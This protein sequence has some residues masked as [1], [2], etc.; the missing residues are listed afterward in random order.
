MKTRASLVGLAVVVVAA[1][2]P[3]A[4]VAAPVAAAPPPV[5]SSISNLRQEVLAIE[6][7]VQADGRKVEMEGEAY[8][9]ESILL[10]RDR[11]KLR[12]TDA[13]IKVEQA[14]VATEKS[15][16]T[17]AAIAAYIGSGG[18]T[19][20]V[21]EFLTTDAND[22]QLVGTYSTTIAQNLD[23]ALNAYLASEHRLDAVKAVQTAEMKAAQAAAT[24]AHKAEVAA[25]A[26]T[27]A[28]EQL[29]SSVKGQLAHAIAAYQ[30]ELLKAAEAAAAAA[31]AREIAAQQAAA[32][33]A[34]KRAHE[35]QQGGGGGTGGGGGGTGDG[36][37][38]GTYP[39]GGSNAGTPATAAQG[40]QAVAAAVKLIGVPYVWGGA[41]PSG[42]DCSGLTMI[43]WDQAG[44]YMDHG[45]TAQYYESTPVSLSNLRPGDLLFYHF[46]NDGPW[47][48][49]HV[50]MYVGSG[51]FGA[52]TV[53]QAAQTGTNV[54]Y[55]PMYFGGFV[56]A[57]RP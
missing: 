51:P 24:A 36:G 38:G 35:H 44:V 45:A 47:P 13:Q 9:E 46:A 27:A 52:N 28:S 29:L 57:G 48:I 53:I 11:I 49:T 22:S 54:S 56:G 18:A 19:V 1:A 6:A 17:D 21:G 3:A 8:L 42:V 15:H 31:R 39:G 43:S 10:Q 4:I 2:C 16:L 14:N 55:Y 33:A 50:V 40:Q 41:S 20:A 25:E 23:N 37:G 7:Q 32:A 26:A 30:E 34:A 12:A 5:P